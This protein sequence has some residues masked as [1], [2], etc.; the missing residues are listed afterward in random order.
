MYERWLANYLLGGLGVTLLLGVAYGLWT[1][2]AW[3]FGS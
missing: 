1:L 2:A 3:A